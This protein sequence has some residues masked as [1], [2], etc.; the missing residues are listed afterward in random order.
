MT[1]VALTTAAGG[2]KRDSG[3]VGPI[4]G[5]AT[6]TFQGGAIRDSGAISM[7]GV[8]VMTATGALKPDVLIDGD[9]TFPLEAPFQSV[10]VISDGDDWWII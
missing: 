7:T 8:G 10:T 6:T 9:E 5:T 2:A 3:A 4:L 1:G